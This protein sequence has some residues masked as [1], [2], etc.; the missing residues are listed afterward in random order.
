MRDVGRVSRDTHLKSPVGRAALAVYCLYTSMLISP[1]AG[2]QM[3]PL[4]G[5]LGA[6]DPH[7]SA[8]FRVGTSHI[9]GTPWTQLWAASGRIAVTDRSASS[10]SW[11][12]LSWVNR[13]PTRETRPPA[14]ASHAQTPPPLQLIGNVSAGA[15]A[16]FCGPLVGRRAMLT[17]S[18]HILNQG[19][20][21]GLPARTGVLNARDPTR[22][23]AWWGLFLSP[24]GCEH[25]FSVSEYPRHRHAKRATQRLKHCDCHRR[26]LPLL[27]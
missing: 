3:C 19:R 23:P 11:A 26:G 1:R 4:R 22:A 27:S 21:L 6:P 2:A 15:A 16:F 9:G 10:G 20:P 7:T 25:V 24:P 5:M 8:W 17:P 13:A 18:A 14:L 12:V